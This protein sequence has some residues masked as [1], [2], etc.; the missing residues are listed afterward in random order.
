MSGHK[1]DRP[2]RELKDIE[3]DINFIGGNSTPRNKCGD[4]IKITEM[5]WIE[6]DITFDE[7]NWTED[8]VYTDGLIES[9]NNIDEEDDYG[10]GDEC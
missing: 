10:N 5:D 7:S 2:P 4:I 1:Y 9:L 6:P 8:D 3:D